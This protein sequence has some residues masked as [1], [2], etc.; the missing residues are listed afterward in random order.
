MNWLPRTAVV[1]PIDFSESAPDAI[2]AAIDLGAT[3]GDVHVLH[4]VTPLD[5]MSSG[6]MLGADDEEERISQARA[7]LA[8]FLKRHD[9]TD[10][11]S[12]VRTGDP[13]RQIT[14]YAHEVRADLI[15]IPS[16]GYHGVKRAILGSIAESVIRH[17]ECAVLVLRRRDA[18]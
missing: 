14:M 7:N 3:P 18:D 6:S 16:H 4:A 15:V 8:D 2:R 1:V 9:L 12:V 5:Y 13:G 10:V 17:A 11:T